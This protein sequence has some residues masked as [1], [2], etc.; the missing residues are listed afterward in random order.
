MPGYEGLSCSRCPTDQHMVKYIL[1]GRDPPSRA[2]G[3]H[4]RNPSTA[5]RILLNSLRQPPSSKKSFA[6]CPHSA[7][8][9]CAAAGPTT[10]H[11]YLDPISSSHVLLLAKKILDSPRTAC[12]IRKLGSLVIARLGVYRALPCP[13]HPNFDVEGSPR[14]S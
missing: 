14:F 6:P 2:P 13:S 4:D 12:L 11:Y 8:R 9:T 7:T 10:R 5:I 1:E 3:H